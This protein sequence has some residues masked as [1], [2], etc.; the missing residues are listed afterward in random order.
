MDYGVYSTVTIRTELFTK[1]EPEVRFREITTEKR[2]SVLW[3]RLPLP[4]SC[5]LQEW[6]TKKVS[7]LL[8]PS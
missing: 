1:G 8:K 2:A 7:S 5:R 6:L 4:A 3:T